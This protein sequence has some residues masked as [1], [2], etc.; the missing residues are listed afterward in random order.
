MMNRRAFVLSA[1]ALALVSSSRLRGKLI[2]ATEITGSLA[3]NICRV[4]QSPAVA[5]SESRQNGHLGSKALPLT[6]PSGKFS[7]FTFVN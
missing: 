7:F 4:L 6:P 1:S 3:G 2:K 5:I